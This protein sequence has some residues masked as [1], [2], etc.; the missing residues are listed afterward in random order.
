MKASGEA[1]QISYTEATLDARSQ[2]QRL[3]LL[4]QGNYASGEALREALGSEIDR[5]IDVLTDAYHRVDGMVDDESYC[6]RVEGLQGEVDDL[7]KSVADETE[8]REAAEARLEELLQAA[9]ETPESVQSRLTVA[10]ARQADHDAE[11]ARMKSRM[12]RAEEQCKIERAE[13]ARARTALDAANYR[14]ASWSADKTAAETADHYRAQ[15]EAAM[16]RERVRLD[17]M[18]AALANARTEAGKSAKAKE[19]VRIV[20]VAWRDI[21]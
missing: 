16:R 2:F 13:A 11:L 14:M 19:I 8:K 10:I 6:A 9:E 5:L 20:E 12:E 4:T 15:Y 21:P 17:S 1:V 18:R 3:R 7:E